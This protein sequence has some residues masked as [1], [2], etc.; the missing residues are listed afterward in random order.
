MKKITTFALIAALVFLSASFSGGCRKKVEP[1]KPTPTPTP[2][3][4]PHIQKIV[5]TYNGNLYWMN[6]DGTG[7]EEIFRD[8]NSKWFPSVSPDGWYVAYWAQ[9]TGNS[10]NLWVGDFKK[11][12]AYQITFDAETIDGE[13][14]NFA[15]SNL[16]AWD[17]DSA[18]LVYSRYRDIWKM[19]R[20]GYDQEALTDNHVNFSPA[21]ASDGRIVYSKTENASTVNLYMRRIDERNEEKITSFNGKKATSPV[22]SPD[23]TKLAYAV[24]DKET[25]NIYI[26]DFKA[27]TDTQLTYDGWSF[28]PCF[29]YDGKELVFASNIV[30]KY[31]P[32]IWKMK[33]DG[34]ERRKLT[35]EGGVYPSW[36]YRITAE[37]PPTPMP[38][39]TL[40]PGQ[41]AAPT[42]QP[43]AVAAA[44]ATVEQEITPEKKDNKLIY[45]LRINFDSGRADIK[46]DFNATLDKMAAEINKFKKSP[47]IIEGHTDNMPI[48]TKI[49]ASNYE[50]SLARANAVKGYF[51]QKHSIDVK[52]I[53]AKG[54]GDE[55]PVATNDTEEGRYKNRRSEIVIII[56]PEE[57]PA[58][59]SATMTATATVTPSPTPKLN[60]MQ[61]LLKP[62]KK[63]GTTGKGANW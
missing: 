19:D 9:S 5:F 63:T 26:K 53:E 61:K 4:I 49:Y 1:P 34:N 15:I 55:K 44:T 10:Y 6:T 43:G 12:K 16:A 13:T 22:F 46:S 17:K 47:V 18:M 35:S 20:E 54:Y 41:K 60:F 51:V 57:M 7:R 8:S 45:E 32:E 59:P 30:D 62:K 21:L 40:V 23:G 11:A 42:I 3:T 28:S 39:P 29:T 24:I 50:L 56:I 48:K 14:Q 58:T 27:K 31:Q 33:L 25:V 38:T 2:T 36:L 37:F 52:R